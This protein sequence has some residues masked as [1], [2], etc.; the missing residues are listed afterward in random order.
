MSR[1]DVTL[2]F[3]TSKIQA[4][5]R[6]LGGRVRKCE[7]EE[8]QMKPQHPGGFQNFLYS[9]ELFNLIPW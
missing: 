1:G 7:K 6:R 8:R 4:Q 5:D 3:L 9:V 2:C